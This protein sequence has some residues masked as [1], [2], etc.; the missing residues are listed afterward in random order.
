MI[1]FFIA[2]ELLIVNS[3]EKAKLELKNEKEKFI[4]FMDNVPNVAWIKDPDNWTFLYINKAWQNF[5]KNTLEQIKNKTDFDLWPKQ[6]A[7]QLRMHDEQ[8]LK[9]GEPIRTYE[10]VPTADRIDH[11]WLVYKFPLY[12]GKKLF[13]AGIATDI[14]DLKKTEDELLKKSEELEKVN[15]LMVDRELK[16]VELKEKIKSLETKKI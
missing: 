16:M 10:S 6:V 1:I 7:E 13:L 3:Y 4:T 5:F 11:K 9:T 2:S 12:L 14:T 8:I 15:A